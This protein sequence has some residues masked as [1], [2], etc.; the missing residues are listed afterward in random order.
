MRN[1][2]D[3]SG[4]EGRKD[5]SGGYAG[6]MPKNPTLNQS[7]SSNHNR[8]EDSNFGSENREAEINPGKLDRNEIDLDRSGVTNSKGHQP[9]EFDGQSEST[10]RSSK[11]QGSQNNRTSNTGTSSPTTGASQSSNQARTGTG[12]SNSNNGSQSSSRK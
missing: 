1:Q 9:Y 11:N 3:V 10:S 2:E 5:Q 4:K 12:S 6:G 7:S 8:N